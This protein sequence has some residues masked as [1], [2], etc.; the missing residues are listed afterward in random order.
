MM[1]K[2]LKV[3]L[4]IGVLLLTVSCFGVR[5]RGSG[6]V[7]SEKRE[8]RDFD[9][10][11]LNS[12]GDVFIEQGDQ[13]GVTIEADDQLME[14]VNAEVRAGK[15]HLDVG[16]NGQSVSVTNAELRYLVTVTD[17]EEI[18]ISGSGDISVDDLSIDDLEIHI[19]GSGDITAE[20]IEGDQLTL[21]IGG[22]GDIEIKEVKLNEVDTGI[23]GSGSIEVSGQTNQHSIRVGGSGSYDAADLE[24]QV[25]DVRIQGSGNAEI[26]AVESLD[27]SIGGSGDVRYYGDPSDLTQSVSGSGDVRGLGD[28]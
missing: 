1:S 24:S 13:P 14:Y 11:Q 17:L 10:V 6:N 7:I 3:S 27:I 26:W 18:R 28:K 20:E 25:V 12:F 16:E 8:V 9:S 5:V 22:S 23:S 4:L 2:L 19:G 15:L 21:S